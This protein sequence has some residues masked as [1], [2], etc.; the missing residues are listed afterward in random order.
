[1]V[2]CDDKMAGDASGDFDDCGVFEASDVSR[3][4]QV[5]DDEGSGK[6]SLAWPRPVL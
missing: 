5:G 3:G 1:M 6:I 2:A 4:P